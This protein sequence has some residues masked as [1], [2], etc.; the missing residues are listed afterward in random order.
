MFKSADP[1]ATAYLPDG[2][3]ITLPELIRRSAPTVAD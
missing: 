2:N 1:V 3:Q